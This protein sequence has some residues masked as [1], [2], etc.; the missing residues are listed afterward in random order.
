MVWQADIRGGLARRAGKAGDKSKLGR[1]FGD[2]E[3][4]RDRRCRS[5]GRERGGAAARRGDHGHTAADEVSHQRRQSI[6]LALQPVVLD[7]HVLSFDGAGFVEAFA[8]R[9]RKSRSRKGG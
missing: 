2:T 9:D 6:V 1:V 3:D 4:D 8:E 5:F 7:P